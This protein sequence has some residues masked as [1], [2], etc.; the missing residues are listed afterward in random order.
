[1]NAHEYLKTHLLLKGGTAINLTIFDLPRLSVNI[2]MDFVPNLPREDMLQ[3]RE[4]ISGIIKAYMASEGYAFF[5]GIIEE[6]AFPEIIKQYNSGGKTAAYDY[7]RSNYGIRH[8]Y[9]VINRIKEC[10]KYS[11]NTDTDQF[12]ETFTTTGDNV[13][14]DLDE[15][16]SRPVI[17]EVCATKSVTDSRPAAME[18]LVRE[19]ISDRLL[20]LSRYITMDSSTRMIL[21]DQTS[22]LLI[23]I[24]GVGQF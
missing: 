1:M 6:K 5:A 19:L 21:I 24:T 10:G 23:F 11:Y 16:C 8:P 15:L 7:I 2:D 4:S 17:S 13:F 22:L 20:T 18:K 3:A 12:S 9:F 14:M